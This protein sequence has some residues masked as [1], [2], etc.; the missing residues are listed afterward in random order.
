MADKNR[1]SNV[2]LDQHIY[3]VFDNYLITLTPNQR[4]R[5]YCSFIPTLSQASAGG[6]LAI[7]G[8][9]TPATTDCSQKIPGVTYSRYD[10]Q[11]GIGWGSRYDGTFPGGPARIGS[12]AARTGS[13]EKV[14]LMFGGVSLTVADPQAPR[15]LTATKYNYARCLKFRQVCTRKARVGSCGPGRWS[16][17][18]TGAIRLDSNM[19]GFHGTQAR[20]STAICVHEGAVDRHVGLLS[21]RAG[22]ATGGRF[23]YRLSCHM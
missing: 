16:R 20:R 23:S 3:S 6:Q 11:K 12:C 9:W 14:T 5:H 18:Q 8:E 4:I 21:A 17:R 2:N 19:D 13:G 7:V 15:S 1:W 22:S 10:K